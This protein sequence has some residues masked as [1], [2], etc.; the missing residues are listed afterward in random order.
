MPPTTGK[1][2]RPNAAP[3]DASEVEFVA[4]DDVAVVTVVVEE[5]CNCNSVNPTEKKGFIGL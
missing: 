4:V 3:A 2:A 1:P 5:S